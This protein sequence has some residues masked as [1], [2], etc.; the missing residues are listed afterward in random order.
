MHAA[1][2]VVKLLS[3]FYLSFLVH[4]RSLCFNIIFTDCID[5]WFLHNGYCFK[6]CPDG[7]YNLSTVSSDSLAEE[8]EDNI[9]NTCLPCHY[10]CKKCEGPVNTQCTE[11]FPD[12]VLTTFSA[13][14]P[15]AVKVDLEANAWYPRVVAMLVV[16]AVLI[17]MVLIWQIYKTKKINKANFYSNIVQHHIQRMEKDVKSAVYIDSE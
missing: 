2:V 16:L 9:T 3:D 10:T 4:F 15:Y 17:T 1:F 8:S 11:C 14:Y 13:C 12:A 7:F 6:N 5:N